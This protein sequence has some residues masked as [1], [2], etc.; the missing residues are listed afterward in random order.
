MTEGNRKDSYIRGLFSSIAGRYDLVNHVASFGLDRGWRRFAARK[1]AVANHSKVLDVCAG[2]GDLALAVSRA[3]NGVQIVATDFCEEMLAVGAA[4]VAG[5]P[6]EALVKFE[7]ADVTAL[8]Y[9]D[10]SFDVV[11]A[12]FGIRNVA[13]VG[14]GLEEVRRVLR[15]GGRFVCLEFSKPTWQ[16]LRRLYGLYLSHVVPL[17]G[18]VLTHNY[19]GYKY[20]ASSIKSFPDQEGLRR[21]MLDAGFSRVD[22]CNLTGGVVAVH[23]AER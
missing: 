6:E 13:E 18:R 4:K 16:P 12:G 23:V 19:D 7:R 5:T 17:I 9:D 8:P 14:R 20:L 1:A 21:M 2:T 10:E 3:L 15:P 22:V 11:T